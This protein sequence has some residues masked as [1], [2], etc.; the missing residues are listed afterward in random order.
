VRD[1]PD[2]RDVSR[3]NRTR[4]CGVISLSLEL[5]YSSFVIHGSLGIALVEGSGGLY[6][7]HPA[8]VV[9]SN[10]SEDDLNW[11]DRA[12]VRFVWFLTNAIPLISSS[13]SFY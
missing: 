7:I 6:L 8:R 2:T 10:P 9:G 4:S 13:L 11:A 1:V 3:E 12:H 5:R